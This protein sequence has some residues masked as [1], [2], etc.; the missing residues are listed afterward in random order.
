MYNKLQDNQYIYINLSSQ[1]LHS[2]IAALK[3]EAKPLTTLNIKAS[4]RHEKRDL[5]GRKDIGGGGRERE[6]TERERERER[7]RE[8]DEVTN[9]FSLG[10]PDL[11]T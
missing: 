6:E 3:Q 10:L 4:W 5:E 9:R 7:E 1:N 2:A 8:N 11:M